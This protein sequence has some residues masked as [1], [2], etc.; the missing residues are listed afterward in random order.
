MLSNLKK[1]LFTAMFMMY[2][3]V[4]AA[5]AQQA[6]LEVN[7]PAIAALKSSMQSR[8]GTL[9]PHYASGAVGL[10]RDGL[11]T[12]RDA[13]AVPL[14][15]RQ[16]VNSAVNDEN[17][18]RQSLYREIARANNHPEW[19]GQVRDTFAQRWVQKAQS[20]WWYQDGGGAWK[21]K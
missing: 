16:A 11:V 4:N 17:R 9:A 12:M 10:T 2:A 1:M 8:H 18:D 19:E 15:Q 5:W 13:N 7:T 14:N 3:F 20:G 6:D 21:Q